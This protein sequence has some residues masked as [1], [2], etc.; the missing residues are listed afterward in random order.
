MEALGW[1]TVDL[2][3]LDGGRNLRWEGVKGA[4][5]CEVRIVLHLL[6]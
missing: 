3:D 4:G 2:R 1:V 5:R 6:N